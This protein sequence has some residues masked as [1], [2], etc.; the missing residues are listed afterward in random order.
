MSTSVDVLN[1]LLKAEYGNVVNRL[2]EADPFVSAASAED[3]L[4]LDRMLADESAHERDLSETIIALRGTPAPRDYPTDVGGLHYLQLSFL[5]P[6]I[7]AAKR[8]L[9]KVYESAGV[10]GDA[11]ADGLKDRI[12]ENHQRDLADVERMHAN[13]AAV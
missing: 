11:G 10:T 12:L 5:M 3:R 1:R 8:A 9:V 6:Q 7:I 4:L 2:R 13:L